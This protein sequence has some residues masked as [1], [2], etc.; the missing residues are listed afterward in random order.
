M[1]NVVIESVLHSP[2]EDASLAHGGQTE[3]EDETLT[4]SRLTI[5]ENGRAVVEPGSSSRGWALRS[6]PMAL[7]LAHL[8]QDASNGFPELWGQAEH[9]SGGGSSNNARSPPSD[10]LRRAQSSAAA[11]TGVGINP[12]S[13]GKGE[14]SHGARPLHSSLPRPSL[15]GRSGQPS[16][17]RSAG[18][19][20]SLIHI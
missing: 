20:L 13:P 10:A 2:R 14:T 12:I 4:P 3:A 15:A 11:L 17:K 16:P 18:R 8:E 9:P 5:D 6:P 19:E 1:D 7:S